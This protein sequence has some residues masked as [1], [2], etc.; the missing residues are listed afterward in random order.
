MPTSSDVGIFYIERRLIL[1]KQLTQKDLE[2]NAQQTEVKMDFSGVQ[3][4]F[5]KYLENE[6]KTKTTR[7]S[8]LRDV[9]GYFNYIA[10]HE[11]CNIENLTVEKVMAYRTM[12]LHSKYKSATINTKINSLLSYNRMLIEE[13]LMADVVVNTSECRI[14]DSELK[15]WRAANIK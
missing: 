6:G 11:D 8:Y 7:G 10:T 5:E 3:Q 2:K 9:V 1:K 15:A 13:K 14:S 4:R 12:L